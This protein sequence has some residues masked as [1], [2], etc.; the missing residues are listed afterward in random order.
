MVFDGFGCNKRSS[1]AA[2]GAGA[3]NEA[4]QSQNSILVWTGMDMNGHTEDGQDQFDWRGKWM[5]FCSCLAVHNP[6][7]PS[8]VDWVL[9]FN[10][11]WIFGKQLQNMCPPKH[12]EVFV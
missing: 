11:L 1:R 5:P 7:K 12:L 6:A 9:S 2:C 3:K 8:N 10:G 4:G